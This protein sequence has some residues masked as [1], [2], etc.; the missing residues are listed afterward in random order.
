MRDHPHPIPVRT[1]SSLVRRS[2]SL[3]VVV[4]EDV[5]QL[6]LCDAQL[7][8]IRRSV[9]VFRLRTRSA[10]ACLASIPKPTLTTARYGVLDMAI[11]FYG[12]CPVCTL[13]A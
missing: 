12:Y 6:L 1:C 10:L 4:L 3:L 9:F 2:H 13:P 11:R 8:L 7:L 5:E